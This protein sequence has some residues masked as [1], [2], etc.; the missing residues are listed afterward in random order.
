MTYHTIL[1][2]LTDPVR[3]KRLMRVALGLRRGAKAHIIGLYAIPSAF[4]LGAGMPGTPNP[5]VFDDLRRQFQESAGEIKAIFEDAC[6]GANCIGEWRS[7]DAA[8]TSVSEVVLQHARSVD[9]VIA[10]Q[11]DGSWTNAEAYDFP[12]VLALE[13]GRPVLIVPNEGPLVPVGRRVVIAWNGRRESARA[14][15]DAVPLL[16]AASAVKVVWAN[17]D[18]EP[19]VA[20][21]V[22]A[23]DLC[24]ALARHGVPC[25]ATTASGHGLSAGAVLLREAKGFGADMLVMGCYGHSRLREFIFGGATAHVLDTTHIPVLMSH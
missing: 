8:E 20:H 23:A 2:H 6:A 9:L 7:V 19:Y 15:F 16:H 22:P 1:V 13:S 18:D 14:A 12:Q 11:V 25:E 4:L 17:A 21:D 24:T 10:S 3:A 5:I